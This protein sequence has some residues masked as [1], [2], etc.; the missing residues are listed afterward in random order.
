M[1]KFKQEED[2]GATVDLAEVEEAV[3]TELES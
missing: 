2:L 1:S 3:P